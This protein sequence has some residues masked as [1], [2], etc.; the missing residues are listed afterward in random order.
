MY[1]RN[2]SVYT[3]EF[4][5]RPGGFG[6]EAGRFAS[7]LAPEHPAAQDLEGACVIPGLID[8]HCHGNSGVDFARCRSVEEI[9]TA[10]RHLARHGVTSLLLSAGS[11]TIE[12]LEVS[13]GQA[14]R[15]MEHTP[16][17]CAYLHGV[18]LEGLFI[19]MEKRGAHDPALIKTPDYAL[20]SRLNAASGG[21]ILLVIIAPEVEGALPFIRQVKEEAVVSV[22]HSNA[23]YEEALRGFEAG[24][25]NVTHLF[26]GMSPF[27]HRQPG[28]VGAAMDSPGVT[29]EVISDGLHLHP[30][31]VRAAFRL[32]GPERVILISDNTA[33]CGMPDGVYEG[34]REIVK[35]GK[36]TLPNGTLAGSGTGLLEDVRRAV[37]FGIP[38]ED[39][40]RCASYNPARAI[41][42]LEHCGSIENGKNAD[43]IIC[44][45]Q[46]S[47]RAVYI[48]GERVS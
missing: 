27:L 4:G 34:G 7:V 25:S 37:S 33:L 31:A 35:E 5:F 9:A 12:N 26:N 23:S 30:A 14:A 20:F 2:A 6:V 48:K 44:D 47:I 43:F 10:T 32:F 38:L 18:H 40:L 15:Y 29:A 39:A 19:S 45:R 11:D 22:A 13:F 24:A 21:N 3:P 41:G 1:F 46:L 17:G 36:I 42:V 28:V 16:P 8:I